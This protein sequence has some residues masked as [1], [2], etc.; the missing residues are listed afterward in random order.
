MHAADE[1]MWEVHFLDE[2]TSATATATAM[3][4]REVVKNDLV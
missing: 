4:L 2:P 1:G 3:M